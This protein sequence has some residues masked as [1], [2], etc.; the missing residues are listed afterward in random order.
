MSPPEFG[1]LNQLAPPLGVTQWINAAGEKMA[2]YDLAK[3]PGR[4]K[5]LFCFQ[6][7]CP[8]CHLKQ[9]PLISTSYRFLQGFQRI[10]LILTEKAQSIII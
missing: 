5:L 1:I 3:M 4:Y 2:D 10:D 6:D 9:K 8:G 7:A